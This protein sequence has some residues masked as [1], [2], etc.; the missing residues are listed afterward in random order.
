MSD[1]PAPN[2][3]L[4]GMMSSAWSDYVPLVTTLLRQVL[5]AAGAAGFTWALTVNASQI[6]MAVSAALVVAS[7]V[8]S[9]IQKIKA[10]HA[11]R[12]AAASPATSAAPKLPA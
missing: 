1:A 8:W 10:K 11:L 3:A 2:E 7:A 5:M 6:Q 9:F 12:V 4:L